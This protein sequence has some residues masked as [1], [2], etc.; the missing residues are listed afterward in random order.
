MLLFSE[1]IWT[2]K[3]VQINSPGV[4]AVMSGNDVRGQIADVSI[5]HRIGV[6]EMAVVFSVEW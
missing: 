4:M 1:I 5:R 6:L 2:S 3:N